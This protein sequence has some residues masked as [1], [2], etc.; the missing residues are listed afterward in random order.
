MVTHIAGTKIWI[1]SCSASDGAWD[2]YQKTLKA[3]ATNIIR[4]DTAIEF[5]G[6][7]K[8]I[9]GIDC[10]ESAQHLATFDVVRNAIE[11]EDKGFDAFVMVSTIDA[12]RREVRDLVEMPSV[13][14]TEC[15]A[16]F[17][18]QFGRFAFLTHN[19]G[20]LNEMER[21]VTDDYGLG[22]YLVRG[23]CLN[24]AYQD[25]QAMY[26]SPARVIDAFSTEARKLIERGAASIVPAGGPVNMFF[27][28][29]G[30]Q[31]VDGVAALDTFGLALK[32]AEMLA[33]LRGLGLARDH[34]ADSRRPQRW[35]Q[36]VAR[37]ARR[38]GDQWH[39]AR[40]DLF[41]GGSCAL[42]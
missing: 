16:R 31:H 27:V 28:H 20:I 32:T 36:R 24:L 5:H 14:I 7:Q 11:A 39:A 34:R 15:A 33:A 37:V 22:R 17:A 19:R 23:A 10:L 42:E 21:M 8:T 38:V 26:E 3:H 25:F 4:A 1:Q 2:I 30:I 9:A 6:L 35:Q 12:G 13:F 40:V 41:R 29:H 18:S